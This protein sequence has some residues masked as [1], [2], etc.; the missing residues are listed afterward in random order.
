MKLST[1]SALTVC[2]VAI[3]PA[4][5]AAAFVAFDGNIPQPDQEN[6]LLNSGSLGLS[7]PG[8]T[9]NTGAI[10]NFTSASQLLTDP[11]SGQARVEAS[12]AGSQVAIDD[13]I[14]I[15]PGTP[16]VSFS[17]VL[18]N[19]F[20][21]GGV[22]V[23]GTL[24]IVASG[25]DVFNAPESTTFTLDDDGDPLAIGNG[26]NFFTVVASGGSRISSLQ[27]I[28]DAGTTYA[29]LRQIRISLVPEPATL[30]LG[31]L[32]LLGVGLIRRR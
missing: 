8:T 9:N 6:I 27:I 22:G 32:G 10:V 11:S 26:S 17:S 4:F 14:T 25:F 19:A 2:A 23:G 12:L 18:F 1:M 15:T 20:V 16:G 30:A 31:G 5:S 28:P 3:F 13:S 7:I 29:D 24:T 21:G